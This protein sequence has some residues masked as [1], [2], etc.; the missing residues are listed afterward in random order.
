[1]LAVA[2]SALADRVAGDRDTVPKLADWPGE[3]APEAL[4]AFTRPRAAPQAD[5]HVQPDRARG[6]AARP[7]PER[8]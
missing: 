1:M 4:A 3:N 5:A 2:K 6:A 7:R 8:H